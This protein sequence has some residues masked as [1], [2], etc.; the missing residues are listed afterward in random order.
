M[1]LRILLQRKE[2][3]SDTSEYCKKIALPLQYSISFLGSND[4]VIYILVSTNIN[5][6]KDM[7]SGN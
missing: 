6:G 5:L 7:D 2:Y 4:E 3:N 1:Q